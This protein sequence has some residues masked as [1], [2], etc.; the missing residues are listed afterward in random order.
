MSAWVISSRNTLTKPQDRHAGE[1]DPQ[2]VGNVAR[3]QDACSDDPQ[4]VGNVARGQDA[5]SDRQPADRKISSWRVKILAVLVLTTGTLSS[6]SATGTY[7]TPDAFLAEMFGAATPAPQVLWLQ[8]EVRDQSEKILGHPLSALRMRYWSQADRYAWILEEIGKEQPI[9]VGIVTT[10]GRIEQLRV[11]I[12]RESRGWEVRHSFFT[13]QFP[14]SGLD[15]SMGL[16][17]TIDGISGATL[18]VSALTRLARL[19][20]LLHRV[21]TTPVP[22]P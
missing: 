10:Q 9:T 12:F 14:G 2:D 7:Q 16:D 1:N 22:A 11:L 19:A 4:D 21:V 20:L 3:G 5:C 15:A 17:N 13:D 18:S 8:P 6:A